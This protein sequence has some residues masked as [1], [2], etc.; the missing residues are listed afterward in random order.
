MHIRPKLL[1]VLVLLDRNEVA[2]GRGELMLAEDI[3]DVAVQL[4]VD[5][6]ETLGLAGHNVS[7]GEVAVDDAALAVAQG[8]GVVDRVLP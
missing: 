1:I 3:D 6:K 7:E 2:G 8:G 5:G 4:A